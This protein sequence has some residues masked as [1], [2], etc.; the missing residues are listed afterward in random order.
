MRD[1]APDLTVT[2]ASFNTRDVLDR[3]LASLY[4]HR[5]DLVLEVIVVD[6]ASS[7]GSAEMV[8]ARWPQA[9]LIRNATN[10]YL[11]GAQNQAIARARGRY[12][13]I[14][15]SDME[16]PEGTLLAMVAWME[17]HPEAGAASCLEV[18]H[19]LPKVPLLSQTP[20]EAILRRTWLR[21]FSPGRPDDFVNHAHDRGLVEAEVISDAFMVARRDA[22][23]SVGRFDETL[24]LYYTE[25][26]LCLRLR[27]AGWKLH[28]VPHAK[29]VHVGH[30]SHS[31][32]TLG[33]LRILWINYHDTRVYFRKHF[34][35]PWGLAVH[36][37][38]LSQ[39]FLLDAPRCLKRKL[40]RRAAAF[41]RHREEAR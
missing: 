35:W 24:R 27:S 12:V 23:E 36:A 17:A 18:L 33:R 38:L 15:N 30:G 16:V 21:A 10:R 29:V 40:R 32:A 28:F 34:G 14:L 6:N 37:A 26:D 13:L 5:G 11:T 7:D 39:Y 41:L 9:T 4:T 3:C 31:V 25:D 1:G 8:A 19:G 22:L 2:I 20:V